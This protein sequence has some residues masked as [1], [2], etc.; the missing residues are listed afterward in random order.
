ML[1]ITPPKLLCASAALCVT[2]KGNDR[3]MALHLETFSEKIYASTDS[4]KEIAELKKKRYDDD[5]EKSRT[6]EFS[7]GKLK[8]RTLGIIMY[9]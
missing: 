8:A 7:L 2:C 3:L 4:G 1:A 5:D 9:S 6:S